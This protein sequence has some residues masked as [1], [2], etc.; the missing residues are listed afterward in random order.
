MFLYVAGTRVRLHDALI[1][2]RLAK[3][4]A[5][6]LVALRNSFRLDEVE[7]EDGKRCAVDGGWVQH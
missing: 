4:P 6:R 5:M 7:F 3:R 1:P 2:V